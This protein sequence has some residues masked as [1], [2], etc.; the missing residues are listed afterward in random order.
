LPTISGVPG[1]SLP[2][3]QRD[4]QWANSIYSKPRKSRSPNRE[5]STTASNRTQSH[6]VAAR[7]ILSAHRSPNET[8]ARLKIFV[9]MSLHDDRKPVAAGGKDIGRL[10][11]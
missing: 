6:Q 2:H 10:A 1:V 8:C 9:G 4:D 5:V 11:I 3:N 7:I